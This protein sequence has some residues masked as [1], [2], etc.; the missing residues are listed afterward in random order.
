MI[1]SEWRK[2]RRS[3]PYTDNCVEI[4]ENAGGGVRLRDTTAPAVVVDIAPG[5]W[6]A[7]V[8][9]VKDGEFDIA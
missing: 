4:R 7:F 6:A 3:G 9:G 1:S 5:S 8:A 2:S